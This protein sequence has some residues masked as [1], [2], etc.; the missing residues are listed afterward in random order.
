MKSQNDTIQ[1]TQ[2]LDEFIND[3]IKDCI[4]EQI[5]G[6][7]EEK[8]I[9]EHWNKKLPNI[10]EKIIN[11]AAVNHLE[12][13]KKRLYEISMKHRLRDNVFQAHQ[14]Q[15]WGKCFAASEVM[16]EL[17]I[18]IANDYTTYVAEEI[19]KIEQ[20]EYQYTYA[21]FVHIHGRV[22][23]IYLEI[24]CLIKNGFADGALARFRTMYELCYIADFIKTAGEETALAYLQQ[25]N[26]DNQKCSWAKNAP[27]FA[28]K[29]K[30]FKPTLLAIRKSC[31]FTEKWEK[32]HKAGCFVNHASPQGTLK[33]LAN[34]DG[35]NMIPVGKSDYG[36]TD[37]AVNSAIILAIVTAMF[38]AIF[39][40]TETLAKSTMLTHWSHIIRKMYLSTDQELFAQLNNKGV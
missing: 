34:I 27:C 38:V 5:A 21:T 9:L 28:H 16:Y 15:K 10:Y 7:M 40:N 29:S 35:M 36:I 37:P 25:S 12:D 22:C 8:Q 6:G 13:I 4:K 17:S 3:V 31:D 26:T 39:P 23:Q 14:D 32:Q 30:N 2:S 19:S 1:K 24:L 20:K 33:R 11:K 18:E